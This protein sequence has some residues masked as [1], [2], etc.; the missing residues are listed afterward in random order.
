M[1]EPLKDAGKGV[2]GG[3]RRGRL[4]SAL[5]VI[6]VALSLLLL[7]GAGLLIRSFVALQTVDLGLNPENILVARVPLPRGQYTTAAQKQQFFRTVLDRIHALPG[8]V[9]A[10]ETTSLPPYG[11]IGTEIEI[12]GK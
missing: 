12:P 11:G 4:R 1:V 10:S 7:V 3:F 9:V 5:V 8:V 2:S 6:E